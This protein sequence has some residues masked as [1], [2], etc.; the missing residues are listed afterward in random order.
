LDLYIKDKNPK[1]PDGV[2]DIDEI[3]KLRGS[4]TRR[5]ARNSSVKRESLT[6]SQAKAMAAAVQN[7][8]SDGASSETTTARTARPSPHETASATTPARAP[9]KSVNEV[10]W[11]A[12]SL[13]AMSHEGI[14]RIESRRDSVRRVRT[15][16][17]N[18][19]RVRE[20]LEHGRAAELALREVLDSVKVAT[21]V[22]IYIS[23]SSPF[24]SVCKP[25][26]VC[27]CCQNS[28]A[29]AK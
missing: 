15:S 10:T 12:S 28:L 23:F 25:M 6:P 8:P 24:S 22:Y 29:L 5:S 19:E 2:H 17:E 20:A 9:F 18:K 27:A 21:Y 3:R 13:S 1:P 14:S 7:S 4:I 26:F 11:Q 16:I